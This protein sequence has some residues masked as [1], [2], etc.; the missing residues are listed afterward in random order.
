MLKPS[1]NNQA[2]DAVARISYALSRWPG[3]DEFSIQR[4]KEYIGSLGWLVV[5]RIGGWSKLGR[6]SYD[7]IGPT[8]QAQWRELA[9][10]LMGKDRMGMVDLPPEVPSLEKSEVATILRLPEFPK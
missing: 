3:D 2:R 1:D 9:I 10:S 4:A 5:N 6:S 8:A 7:E